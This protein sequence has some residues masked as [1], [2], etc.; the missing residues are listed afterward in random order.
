MLFRETRRIHRKVYIILTYFGYISKKQKK[1]PG[2]ICQP[3]RMN[4][5]L[6]SREDRYLRT[7]SATLKMMAWSNWR[8]SSP[9]SFLIF[10][11][12]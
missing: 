11:N 9:V 5:Y 7:I 10:S 2:L 3:R 1:A 6:A 12:R 4:F 8:R